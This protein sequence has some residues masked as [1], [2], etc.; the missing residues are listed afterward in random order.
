MVKASVWVL[1]VGLLAGCGDS[2]TNPTTAGG[3][4]DIRGMWVGSRA[5][6]AH[7][8]DGTTT[9]NVCAERWTIQTQFNASFAGA[10]ETGGA[11]CLQQAGSLEGTITTA[12]AIATLS[13]NMQL[14]EGGPCAVVAQ[15]ALNGGFVGRTVDI[16]FAD[17]ITCSSGSATFRS[18]RR[19]VVVALTK[20]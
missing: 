6:D 8:D 10:F 20:Q 1:F 16:R 17:E 11:P 2:P 19:T 12:G 4:P 7:L 18:T 9:N 13:I 5:V 15:S 3:F 14:G